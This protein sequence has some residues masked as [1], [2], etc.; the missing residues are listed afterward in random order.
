MSADDNDSETLEVKPYGLVGRLIMFLLITGPGTLIAFGLW[1]RIG[2]SMSGGGRSDT[3]STV[4][5]VCWLLG[6]AGSAFAI[7]KR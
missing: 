5:F 3:I 1:V 6:L 7:F 2:G 4:A